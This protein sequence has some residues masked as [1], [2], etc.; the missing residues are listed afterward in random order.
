MKYEPRVAL[1]MIVSDR[2]GQ[3]N[4]RVAGVGILDQ[5][6]FPR[7]SNCTEFVLSGRESFVSDDKLKRDLRNQPVP[8]LTV[9]CCHTGHQH[10]PSDDQQRRHAFKNPTSHLSSSCLL[11]KRSKLIRLETL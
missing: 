4:G 1:R 2:T 7:S 11:A 8:R 5:Q 10:P 9:G 3:A 6:R